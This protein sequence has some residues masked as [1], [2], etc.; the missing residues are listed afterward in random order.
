MS[1]AQVSKRG[2]CRTDLRRTPHLARPSSV[3]RV[4]L[5]SWRLQHKAY[6][7]NLYFCVGAHFYTSQTAV[8]FT[9]SICT[10]KC[11]RVAIALTIRYPVHQYRIQASLA[12]VRH[13]KEPSRLSFVC[14]YILKQNMKLSGSRKDTPL[15]S[16]SNFSHLHS[17]VAIL[18]ATWQH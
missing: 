18:P 5:N 11:K 7:T 16:A 12:Y 10:M 8:N 4:V 17:T 3:R 2:L 15:H 6:V 13:A 14:N 9:I 1:I